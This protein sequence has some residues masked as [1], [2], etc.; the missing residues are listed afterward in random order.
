MARVIGMLMSPCVRGVPRGVPRSVALVAVVSSVFLSCTRPTS[1]LTAPGVSVNVSVTT[2]APT[3]LP[4]QTVMATATAF[5]SGG[6]VIDSVDVASSGVLT[7]AQSVPV[8][9]AGAFTTTQ[10][11]TVPATVRTGLLTITATAHAGSAIGHG[12][13]QVTVADTSHPTFQ[14]TTAPAAGSIVEPGD[15]VRVRLTASDAVAVAYTTVKATGAFTLRDSANAGAVATVQRTVTWV[16][17]AAATL[18]SAVHIT[19][20]VANNAGLTTTTT[21]SL[22]VADTAHPVVSGTLTGTHGVGGAAPGDVITITVKASDR[23]KLAYVGYAF[24]APASRVDSVAT[25]ASSYT[26]TA[27]ITVPA[28]WTGTSTVTVFARDS[29]GNRTSVSLGTLVVRTQRP[30]LTVSLPGAVYDAAFDRTRNVAYLSIPSRE[31]VVVL[32]T[33]NGTFGTPYT[34]TA[35]PRGVDLTAGGDSLVVGLLAVPA[36]IAITNLVSGATTLLP[37]PTTNAAAPSL[38]LG[39]DHVRVAGTNKALV[40]VTFAGSGYGG[41]LMEADLATGNNAV[42]QSGDRGGAVSRDGQS[43]AHRGAHW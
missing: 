18:N 8:G 41:L 3:A 10:Q 2:A 20:T 21:A 34:F 36:N 28:Q 22:T 31:Q 6:A 11:F 1:G 12:Q 5:A 23:R 13:T 26:L 38:V 32:S 7:T 42:P 30:L 40:T 9:V 29:V 35:S 43:R 15:T 39:P 27:P 16:V 4:G 25:S 19:G 14:M 17:P 24:G 37:I 33:A